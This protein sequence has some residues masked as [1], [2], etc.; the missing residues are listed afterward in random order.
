M[1]KL[2]AETQ[3]VPL[4]QPWK[5]RNSVTTPYYQ[6]MHAFVV[7]THT[8][9][10]KAVNFQAFAPGGYLPSLL[11]SAFCSELGRWQGDEKYLV[12]FFQGV[13]SFSSLFFAKCRFSLVLF[14]HMK[15][16]WMFSKTMP[17]LYSRC[18]LVL[19]MAVSYMFLS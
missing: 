19:S 6:Q 2:P 1:F 5:T 7:K 14:H 17:I 12:C 13:W 4:W 15:W 18:F 11:K 8:P 10:S 9:L 3:P 16:L